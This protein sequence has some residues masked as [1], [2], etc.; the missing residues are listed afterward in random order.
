MKILL[1]LSLYTLACSHLQPF[2]SRIKRSTQVKISN[3]SSTKVL[4]IGGGI[5]G[6]EAARLLQ[7]NGIQTL[8]LE[9]RNRTGGRI[10]SIRSKNGLML[11]MGAR[12]IH[13]I[14]GSIPSGLLTN[15]IWDYTQETNISICTATGEHDFLGSY[16][17]DNI[18]DSISAI[19]NWYD[20]Y[21]VFVRDET[22]LLP[23]SSNISFAYYANL[24]AQQKNFTQKQ[25]DA[26]YNYVYFTLAD[27]EGAELDAVAAKGYLDITSTHYGKEPVICDKGYMT[28]TD[29]LAKDLT[30]IR[31]KQVVTKI[32]YTNNDVIVST[33]DGDVY[34]ADYVLITVP[35]GV[36]KSK[37]IEFYPS[38]PQWKLNAI[39][40]IG[41]GHYEKIYLLWNEPWW[42]FTNFYFFRPAS[43]NNSTEWR[44]WIS[45]NKWNGIPS[46][47]CIFAGNAVSSLTWKQNENETVKEIHETLQI[48]FPHIVIPSPSEVY[49]SNWNN[50][51]FSYGSYS[52]ISVNQKYEDPLYLSEPVENR[53]LFAGEATS[54]DS[55]GYSH[56][57][58]LTARREVTR[59]LYV[60]NLLPK[61]N[62]T[63]SRSTKTTSLNIF[64]ILIFMII[65]V[66][67]CFISSN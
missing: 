37:Q 15:P 40:R 1:F 5:S 52:Y 28:I 45:A 17:F 16:P 3:T 39:D 62:S 12:Y 57:A 22:R 38:L 43:I 32:N 67:F 53:L 33:K 9:A 23:S 60:Y 41:F 64:I 48:M 46:I 50:D 65:I 24:F 8:V 20:E 19:Q 14:R 29:H 63:T 13:G 26:F 47:T 27:R 58:L 59:L 4:I 36:L 2:H 44:Y 30:N 7:Q 10:W 31:L 55:Y 21:M 42:N 34:R 35:L 11:D 56:G 61:Q 49:M 18:S 6:L 54:S 25:H 51:S 66:F